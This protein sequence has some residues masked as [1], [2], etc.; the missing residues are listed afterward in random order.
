M[1]LRGFI[2]IGGRRIQ[3]GVILPRVGEA[4]FFEVPTRLKQR[5]IASSVWNGEKC[6]LSYGCLEKSP[7][8]TSND[9]QPFDLLMRFFRNGVFEAPTLGSA[10]EVLCS[11]LPA[12]REK[13]KR[14]E[15]IAFWATG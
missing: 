5:I 6:Q 1:A 15:G 4:G 13:A 14:L 12:G 11:A 8:F 9:F 7:I 10:C 2:G 3:D